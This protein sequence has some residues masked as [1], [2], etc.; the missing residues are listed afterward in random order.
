MIALVV[1]KIKLMVESI[2]WREIN[3]LSTSIC[4]LSAALLCLS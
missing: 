4:P 2:F 1:H 3:I